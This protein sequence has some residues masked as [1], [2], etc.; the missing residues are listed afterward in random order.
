MFQFPDYVLLV[1]FSQKS[2]AL[3]TPSSFRWV[4]DN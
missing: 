4:I 1:L 2:T 3:K